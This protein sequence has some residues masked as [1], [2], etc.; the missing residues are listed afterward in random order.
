MPFGAECLDGG[1][2]RFRLWAPAA[3][4]VTLVL[5]S[6]GGTRLAPMRSA[7][8]GWWELV[9]PAP[10]GARYRFRV[11][12]GLEVPDPASRCNPD[13]VHGPSEVID[14]VAYE[15]HDASWRGRPWHEAVLY[16]LHVGA[17]TPVGSFP[18][19]L[20]QLPR[21]RDLGVTA[22]EL[23]PV[24]EFAGNRNWGY[25]GVL[26]YAPHRG[27]GRPEELKQLVDE[28]H[29]LGLMVMLDVVYNHFGPEGN[30]LHAYAPQFFTS[31]H[32]TP[33]GDAID[34]DGANA[35]VV[36]EFFIH[37]A[38]YWLEEFH[39]DGL[40]LDAAHA[41]AD[42]SR[43]DILAELAH[44]ARQGPGRERHIHLVL[45]NDRND[46]GRLE[47]VAG[48]PVAYDAQWNDDF[49]HASHVL[50]TGEGDGYYA[51]YVERPAWLLGRALAEGFSYQGEQSEFRGQP[52]GAPSAGLPPA[53]FVNFLQ[54]H[55]QVGNRACGERMTGLASPDAIRA[56]LTLLL[57]APSIPLMFMGEEFGSIQPFPFFCDFG[58][59]LAR[60]VT[61]G[62]RNEFARFDRFADPAAREAIPD[63]NAAA[64]FEHARIDWAQA[65]Q[66]GHAASQAYVTELLALRRE[67]IV[68]L[69]PNLV[70][71]AGR[72]DAEG[73]AV[74]HAE[75][76]SGD[77]TTL[78]VL[79]NLSRNAAGTRH[80]VRG[81]ILYSHPAEVIETLRQQLLPPWSVVWMQAGP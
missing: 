80:T 66:P 25:D 24:A 34:F 33:W 36:R 75:W 59:D 32:R 16:E 35:R 42:E 48:A 61:A 65:S 64:T 79:T 6:H 55:D 52:R 11:G 41:I 73:A 56:G 68:P 69:I 21:L 13:G 28:A 53:A 27:Y 4:E 39:L 46:A 26:P 58:G 78:A 22:I 47:R 5:A 19:A 7:T 10:T 67:R 17:F 2:A 38:L 50:L 9:T 37:N 60:A 63:P 8:E 76:R 72:F 14:P 71:G 43:P 45:E 31:R 81:R 54:N 20:R 1:H 3:R 51:D 74:I 15:W 57:L 18:G 62:R 12:D 29:R 77:G 23:M 44:E 40:R 30:Y 49:H 70:A